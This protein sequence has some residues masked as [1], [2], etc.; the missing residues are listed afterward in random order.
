[1]KMFVLWPPRCVKLNRTSE[2]QNDALMHREGL[3]SSTETTLDVCRRQ[4]MTC[5]IDLRTEWVYW[6]HTHNIGIQMNRKELAKT[7][8][9]WKPPF[10][11]DVFLQ[12]NSAF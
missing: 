12:N 11:R 1:M 3:T 6:P 9:M 5:N 4:I 2:M 10:V 7:F 8:M